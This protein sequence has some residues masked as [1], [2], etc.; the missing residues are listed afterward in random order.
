MWKVE[1]E[2]GRVESGEQNV[3]FGMYNV[4]RINLILEKQN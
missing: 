2:K 1:S 4:K 3:N